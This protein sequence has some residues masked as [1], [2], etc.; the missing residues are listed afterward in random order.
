ML[1]PKCG[2]ISFDHFSACVKC[3]NDLSLIGADLH[4][5][6]TDSACRHFLGLALKEDSTFQENQ[7]AMDETSLAFAGPLSSGDW[8]EP[9]AQGERVKNA[10]QAVVSRGDTLGEEDDVAAAFPA[11]ESP[12][13]EFDLDEIPHL[14]M[15]GFESAVADNKATTDEGAPDVEELPPIDLGKDEVRD[16]GGDS[17]RSPFLPEG[18]PADDKPEIGGESLEI[19]TL[20]LTLDPGQ[21]SLD[22]ALGEEVDQFSSPQP[23]EGESSEQLTIDLNEIDLSD[24]VRDQG[25]TASAGDDA[26]ASPE[27]RG[28]DFEDTMDLSLFVGDSHDAPVGSAPFP[29]DAG[30]EPIDL[31]LM[32]EAL[33]ELAVDPGR[34]E[35]SFLKE[36]APTGELELSMEDNPK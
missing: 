28:L 35:P 30:P 7:P 23:T 8:K 13:L 16:R 6:A 12:A 27:G 34:K 24:L 18:S 32:D 33:I 17:L 19:D 3:H 29:S 20:S 1:C 21:S 2:F 26:G 25:G 10:G 22:E 5:T 4:G 15:S 14:D 11:D 36:E 31:T 9:F